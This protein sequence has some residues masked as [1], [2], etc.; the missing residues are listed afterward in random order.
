MERGSL[1]VYRDC[2]PVVDAKYGSSDDESPV[3][4]IVEALAEATG[5]DP[6]DLPPLFEFVNPDAIDQLFKKHDDASHAN[7]VLSFQFKTWNVFV[8]ADGRI[9][10]CD[11]TR[12]TNPEP[13][14]ES[15]PA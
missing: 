15:A 12:S 1:T 11:N 14:F 5:V 3:V 6:T 4:V 9:R 2:V 10:V 7:A 13:V 8:R